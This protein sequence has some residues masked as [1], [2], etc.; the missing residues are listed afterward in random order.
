M[1]YMTLIL[2]EVF[3]FAAKKGEKLDSW[4]AYVCYGNYIIPK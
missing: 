2:S 4:N 1:W 3:F